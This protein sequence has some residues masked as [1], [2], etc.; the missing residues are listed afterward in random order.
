MCDFISYQS[1]AENLAQGI[2]SQ[3]EITG[4][5]PSLRI[6]ITA[7]ESLM[8]LCCQV[9]IKASGSFDHSAKATLYSTVSC[10]AITVQSMVMVQAK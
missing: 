6:L 5:S 8:R 2:S 7:I 1:F 9:W 3:S 4:H 10:T